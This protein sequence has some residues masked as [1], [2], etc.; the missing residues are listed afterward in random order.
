MSNEITTAI[1]GQGYNNV[2]E[3]NTTI[4]RSSEEAQ[5]QP[6][7]LEEAIGVGRMSRAGSAKKK[8]NSHEE[9]SNRLLSNQSAV[10][11]RRNR[12]ARQYFPKRKENPNNAFAERRD[13][14]D[15]FP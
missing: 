5:Y 2:Q 12:N 1:K 13:N 8:K 7:K 3:R 14:V 4:S 11:E 10:I 15:T 9:L 6:V